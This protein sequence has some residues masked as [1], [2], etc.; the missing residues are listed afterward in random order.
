MNTDQ[1][2]DALLEAGISEQTLQIVTN[3]NGYS[4]ET[5]TDILYA[6]FGERQFD[7]EDDDD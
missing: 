3:I 5:M 4:E 7:F 6:A 1:M 2:W